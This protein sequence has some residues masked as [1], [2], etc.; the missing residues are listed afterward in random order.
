MTRA[1]DVANVLSTA[2][3]L[4]T[5]A[6]TAAA[7]SS[8]NSANDPHGDRANA[9]TLYA[10]LTNPT[11]TAIGGD[12]GGQINLAT[13]VTNSTLSGPINFDVWRNKVRLFEGGGNN[14]GA[15][16]DLSTLLNG[17]GSE[18][19][20]A[21][22]Q[23]GNSG[24]YLTTDGTNATWATVSGGSSAWTLK[25]SGT[26]SSSSVNVGSINAAEILVVLPSFVQSS[27]S[28]PE[29]RVNNDAT[30]GNYGVQYHESLTGVRMWG[31]GTSGKAFVY[32]NGANTTAAMKFG[33]ANLYPCYIRVSS[34]FTS[35]Q[36]VAGGG[37]TWS[38]GSYEVW[39]R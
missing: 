34:A 17:V 6:E 28:A 26:L 12:E 27:S 2:T 22:P 14:R 39:T 19:I 21:A 36:I 24:K 3:A 38:S 7:I 5:D 31:S 9:A 20:A 35:I 33:L 13:A 25:A 15:S 1:R 11:F 23:S 32:I 30:S 37:G 29:V 10:P 16:I 4:A 8:H 18:L